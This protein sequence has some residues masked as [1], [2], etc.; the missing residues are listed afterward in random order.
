MEAAKQA[1]KQ[2]S[3]QTRSLLRGEIRN[4]R[5]RRLPCARDHQDLHAASKPTSER[6]ING[7]IEHF[8]KYLHMYI[9]PGCLAEQIDENP[10]VV[11]TFKHL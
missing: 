5:L 7:V 2:A 1:S 11:C 3:R 6:A 8:R 10:L 9:C 4:I